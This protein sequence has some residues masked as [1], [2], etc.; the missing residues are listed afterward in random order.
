MSM[1]QTN[2]EAPQMEGTS[3][4]EMLTILHTVHTLNTERLAY[5][6]VALKTIHLVTQM[7]EDDREE[8][9]KEFLQHV[10][11]LHISYIVYLNV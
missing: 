7:L 9:C 2:V 6:F 10:E 5:K 3:I 8:E 1:F 4:I 11:R